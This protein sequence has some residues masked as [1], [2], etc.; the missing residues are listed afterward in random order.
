MLTLLDIAKINGSDEHVGLIDEAMRNVPEIS[1]KVKYRGQMVSVPNVGASRTLKGRMYKTRV[2]ITLP[3]VG[4]RDAND[5]SDAVNSIFENRLVETFIMN[6]RWECDVAVAD[7]NEDGPEALI[8]EE[9]DAILNAALMALGKQFYYGR[10]GADGKGHPGLIDAVDSS[11]IVDATGSTADTASS[12]WAVK[13]G[14]QAVQWVFGDKGSLE[15]SEVR[16]E[17]ILGQNNKRLTAYVQELLCYPGVQVAGK[18]SVA[19]IKNLTAQ[20]G[21]GLTDSLLDDLLSAFPVGQEPDAI[22]G[23]KR[24]LSQLRKSRTATNATGA[25]AP[26]PQ[27]YEGVP[28]IATE[29]ILNTE[30]I[31]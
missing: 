11:M 25:E 4:F 23:T 3:V 14:P 8:A 7:S 24:S 29:S 16:K 21:K 6:P 27:D 20:A 2:R 22:F 31:V 12:V 9:A 10:N 30:A 18:Y 17:S 26:T 5:G 19:K 13:F 28:L 15:M 1:G